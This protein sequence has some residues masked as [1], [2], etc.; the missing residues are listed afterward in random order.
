MNNNIKL[1]GKKLNIEKEAPSNLDLIRYPEWAKGTN[2]KLFGLTKLLYS[3][4]KNKTDY[5]SPRIFDYE[6]Y[7]AKEDGFLKFIDYALRF[8]PYTISKVLKPNILLKDYNPDESI[9][10][11]MIEKDGDIDYLLL[12]MNAKKRLNSKDIYFSSGSYYNSSNNG[13]EMLDYNILISVELKNDFGNIALTRS[14]NKNHTIDNDINYGNSDF[15]KSASRDVLFEVKHPKL[16]KCLNRNIF[17]DT[18]ENVELAKE[19]FLC[20][21]YG[22]FDVDI[23]ILDKLHHPQNR[24]VLLDM[25]DKILDED[26]ALEEALI[27]FAN[28]NK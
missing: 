12:L 21:Y 5:M 19:F 23:S 15:D 25:L 27:N 17:E 7:E 22:S 28:F 26:A 11:C 13:K 1:Y 16:Y 20:L 4:N 6:I 2:Y 9:S 3:L 18:D 8:T 24:A 14:L 10:L